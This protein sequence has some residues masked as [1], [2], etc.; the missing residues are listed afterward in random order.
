MFSRRLWLISC[1]LSLAAVYPLYVEQ[2]WFE[3][4]RTPIHVPGLT[5][6]VRVLHLSD[7]HV[8]DPLGVGEVLEA[9]EPGLAERPDLIVLTGD[10]IESQGALRSHRI[11]EMAAALAKVAP[12]Y[13]VMGNHDSES[14]DLSGR[15]VPTGPVR[16]VFERGGAKVLENEWARVKVREQELLLVGL[17]DLWARQTRPAEAFGGAP[18]GLPTILLTH[19]PDTKD[20]A[21]AFPWDLMLAGHTHGNQ[22]NLPWFDE[23][24]TTV[25]DRRFLKGL[26]HWEGR[27]LFVSRGLG[28]VK[29]VR[30]NSRPEVSILELVP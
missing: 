12:V 4:T 9:V 2:R 7:L 13:V 25:R 3:L 17:G 11:D 10:N 23:P 26:H 15:R 18:K 16:A 8:G 1:V 24:W 5:A 28:G 30:F 20:V 14:F 29:G 27:Q 19:N 6:P 21:R 22:V